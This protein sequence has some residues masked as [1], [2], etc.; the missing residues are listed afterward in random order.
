MPALLKPILPQVNAL[1]GGLFLLTAF[2]IVATR[3]AL[4]CLKFF[5]AQ[6]LLLATSAFVLAWLLGSRELVAVGILTLV[7]KPLLIPLLLRRAAGAEIYTRREV[8]Q[9]ISIPAALLLALGFA[10]LSYALAQPAIRAVGA[11][12]TVATNLPIGLAGLLMGAL[13]LAVRREAVPQ[14]IA[15]LAM[16]NG[17]Y[18]A[19][20]A[21]APNLPL[22]VELAIASDILVVTVVMGLLTRTIREH[23]GTTSVAALQTLKE[24]DPE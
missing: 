3:Q 7:T 14:L 18:F 10:I 1:S 13:T 8:D 16:E 12:P 4:G 15:I 23:I 19:G 22:I 6:S 24:G 17:A 2:A 11:G 20:I 21:I 5:V 9:V